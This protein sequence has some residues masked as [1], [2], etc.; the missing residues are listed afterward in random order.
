VLRVTVL[1]VVLSGGCSL[2][3]ARL[4][5]AKARLSEQAADPRCGPVGIRR[6]AL[7][8][9]W[10]EYLRVHVKTPAPLRGEARLHVGAR[11]LPLKAFAVTG[12]EMVFE[13]R[14]PNEKLSVPSGLA[15]NLVLDLTLT[16]LSTT[17]GDC[18]GVEVTIE[19]GA[20]LPTVEEQVWVNELIARGGPDV[21]AWRAQQA[22]KAVA[23]QTPAPPPPPRAPRIAARPNTIARQGSGETEW[24]QWVGE[25][26]SGAEAARWAEW[27]LANI[28]RG[29]GEGAALARGAWVVLVSRGDE[30]RAN[31]EAAAAH[32]QV[33]APRTA[34]ELTLLLSMIRSEVETD[35]A[36]MLTL[37]AGRAATSEA[38]AKAG[39]AAPLDRLA[40]FLPRDKTRAAEAASQALMFV[41]AFELTWPLPSTPR[42]S[43]AFGYRNHPTLGG[44]RLHTGVDLSVPSGTQ[45]HA[46]GAGVVVRAG[47]DAVNG[48]YLVIDHGFGVTTAYLHNTEVLVVEGQQIAAGDLVSLSGNT[49]RSTGPHLHYQLEL[50]RR[51]VDPLLF[52]P[53][54][55][56]SPE[57]VATTHAHF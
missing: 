25:E 42:V 6:A 37:F 4:E 44:V 53:R 13:A 35:D 19:Q 34:R 20:F 23:R 16:E 51:P 7:A 1:L 11:P 56:P 41:T 36:A 32:Y 27:P 52:N 33:P 22:P 50:E 10:G 2:R 39:A 40:P 15:K 17:A 54:P 5:T 8:S 18:N 30:V 55:Q 3:Q 43:S 47:S 28:I 31:T 26:A 38:T 9:R 57:L 14:W 49:G 24:A 12:A 48:R 29:A 45:V 46:T 21:D